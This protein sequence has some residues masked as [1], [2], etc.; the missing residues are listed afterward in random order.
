MIV[1]LDDSRDDGDDVWHVYHAD[2]SGVRQYDHNHQ[3]YLHHHLSRLV[4][5]FR[6]KMVFNRQTLL[7][8]LF[9]WEKLLN[10]ISCS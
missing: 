1:R 7:I 10:N 3:H 4:A 9:D 5:L 8:E 6:E 2:K